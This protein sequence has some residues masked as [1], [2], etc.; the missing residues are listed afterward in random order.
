MRLKVV[1]TGDAWSRRDFLGLLGMGGLVACSP[2]RERIV[3]YVVQ[4]PEVRPGVP[5]Y[6]ASSMVIGGTATGLLVESHVGRPTK[7]EG[8]PDHPA[9]LGAT[10]LQHQASILDLYDPRRARHA[11]GAADWA[12]FV[13]R[14]GGAPLGA[15]HDTGDGLHFVLAPTSSPLVIRLIEQVRERFPQAS[16]HFHDPLHAPAAL[17]AGRAA[18]GRVLATQRRFDRAQIVLAIDSDFLG[19]GPFGVRWAHDF[20]AGRRVRATDGAM[21]RL[22]VAEADLT[23]TGAAA[24]HRLRAAPG[25]LPQVLAAIARALPG[26]SEPL[27]RLPAE[28]P[29][30]AWAEAVARD[31]VRHRGRSAIVVGER[32]PAEVHLLAY[33]I[34]RLLGN[35]GETVAYTEHPIYEAGEVSHDLRGLHRAMDAGAVRTLVLLDVDPARGFAGDRFLARLQRVPLSIC[36]AQRE[37]DTSRACTVFVPGVHW[38]ESWGDARAYDGTLSFI[39]PLVRPLWGGRSVEELLA[40]FAGLPDQNP[41][42]LLREL[43]RERLGADGWTEALR[44]GVVDGMAFATVAVQPAPDATASALEQLRARTPPGLVISLREDPKLLDGTFAHNDW[45]LELPD[46][47]HKLCWDNAALLS[48]TTAE[49]LDVREGDLLELRH[50]DRS[51]RAPAFPFPGIADD[52]ISLSFGWGAFHEKENRYVG[53][54]AYPLR[55]RDAPFFLSGAMAVRIDQESAAGRTLPE[56]AE[57]VSGQ[58]HLDM[59]GRPILRSAN[60]ADFRVDPT[61]AIPQ[62]TPLSLYEPPRTEGV[63]QWGMGIDLTT[64]TGCAACVIACQ[65][66]NNLPVV[67]KVGVSKGRA[68][69]GLRIDRY[70]L[71]SGGDDVLLLPQPMLCQ[72]CEMAPCEYVCPVNATVHSP[73]GLNEMVYNRCIGTRFC[74]NNC[75]YKVRRFNFF[76]LNDDLA[77]TEKM[78]KNP[79]VTVRARG[80]MEKC[81][82]CV[83]R[84]RAKDIESRIRGAPI[85]DGEVQTAC[86]AACPTRAI[87]FGPITQPDA[88]VTRQHALPHAYGVLDHELG[89]RP[90]VRYLAHLRNVNDEVPA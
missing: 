90:R 78:Q 17:E 48:P 60:L 85:R 30:R 8:N 45:L 71:G 64:C 40:V 6:Y 15:Q 82:F 72:H 73:D 81:S 69:H 50:G 4:P 57:L 20:A 74:S 26:S 43:H 53:T 32:Q 51:I 76:D 75:P 25:D 5:S 41:H 31:L 12:T 83:Q 47:V 16:F 59:Q 13:A 61:L 65:A 55:T 35:V 49:K 36:L 77:E 62:E 84:I 9:S 52:T 89:T 86:Q 27:A 46:P 14:F 2:P 21:N 28:L 66:E 68:M 88:E 80:V 3:P 23:L 18:F 39:Q 44:R 11:R 24:D 38:L 42:H 7:I 33:E 1:G 63:V 54:D 87:T 70:L 37:S 19:H 79:D 22:Y 67:G 58:P 29:Y 10:G 56:R 34:D